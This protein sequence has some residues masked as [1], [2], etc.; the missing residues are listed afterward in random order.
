MNLSEPLGEPSPSMTAA[1][2]EIFNALRTSTQLTEADR[3]A[4]EIRAW[5]QTMLNALL[6]L[7]DVRPM[8]KPPD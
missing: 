3:R 2:V 7:H 8:K 6:E 5:L 4:T 1:E